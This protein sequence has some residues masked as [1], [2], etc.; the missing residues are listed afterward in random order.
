[1][2]NKMVKLFVSFQKNFLQV[3]ELGGINLETESAQNGPFFIPATDFLDRVPTDNSDF[4]QLYECGCVLVI[5]KY[6]K[7]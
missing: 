4:L 6:Q 7:I 5:S 3:E 1:M 2:K